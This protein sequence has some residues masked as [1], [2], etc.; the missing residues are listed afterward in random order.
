[1][2]Q[3][4]VCNFCS[5]YY[6]LF[7]LVVI[8]NTNASQTPAYHPH[9]FN[10]NP[11]HLEPSKSH[12]FKI[13]P[14]FEG[15]IILLLLVIGFIAFIIISADDS[16]HGGLSPGTDQRFSGSVWQRNEEKRSGGKWNYKKRIEYVRRM[17]LKMNRGKVKPMVLPPQ[18]TEEL[19][20]D[21][22]SMDLN[23]IVHGVETSIDRKHGHRDRGYRENSLDRE[24]NSLLG[25]YTGDDPDVEMQDIASLVLNPHRP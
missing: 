6:L 8:G 4:P 12:E 21:S 24:A 9:G 23:V 10:P 1:M 5:P 7:V 3:I 2:I 22:E 25:A 17:T 18:C 14:V 11:D 13:L 20:S 19:E 16:P 15:V